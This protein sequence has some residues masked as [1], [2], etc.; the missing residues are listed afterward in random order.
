[1]KNTTGKDITKLGELWQ[2]EIMNLSDTQPESLDALEN[3]I[4]DILHRLGKA[5]IECKLAEWNSSLN[6]DKSKDKC[7]KCDSKVHN[8]KRTKQILTTVATIDYERYMIHCPK[9]NNTEYPLDK[10]LGL[11]PLQR[12]SSSVEELAILC[13]ASWDYG[14]SEYILGKLLRHDKLS[15][16]TIQEKTN[17]VGSSI[18]KELEGSK[19]KELES[20]KRLQGDYF[21]SMK[22]WSPPKL[23]IYVD[24]DGVMI[25]S[26]DNAKRMEG[27]VGLVW[28]ERELVK[29]A[30]YSHTDK[31]YI[32]TFTD[33][34]RFKWDM[35][36]EIYKRSGGN[37]DGVEVLVRG[38]GASWINGFRMEHLPRSRYILDHHHLCEKVKE[39][40][41]SVIENVRDCRKSVDELMG[42][43][44]AGEVD[45]ALSYIDGVSK[46]YR[47]KEKLE[48]LKKLSSY[49]ERN[50]EGI[51]YAEEARHIHRQWFSR[52]SR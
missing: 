46:R 33:L 43:L 27:K 32:G 11:H 45:I 12:M 24:M 25:N 2:E 22:L 19:I 13:G 17:A 23:R 44:N 52:Q 1:M 31:R 26:R 49:I 8:R 16:E 4:Q 47:K 3:R 18:S 37:L 21:A 39:R 7:P 20:N 38:D 42:I 5:M 51:W 9:C 10:I 35:V 48:A 30:T 36:S 29:E 50:R 6:K 14:K 28:S 34:E 40:I 15:H 41:G